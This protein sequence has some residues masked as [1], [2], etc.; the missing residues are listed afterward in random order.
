MGCSKSSSESQVCSNTY[1]YIYVYIHKEIRKISN[2]L[3]LHIKE[4]E[5]EKKNKL[6]VSRRREVINVK[7]EVNKTD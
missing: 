5:K 3:T 1:T 7:S 2:N 6:D 4:V